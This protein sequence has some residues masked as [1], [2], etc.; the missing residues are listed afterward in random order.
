MAAHLRS[1]I[2]TTDHF[3]VKV[4]ANAESRDMV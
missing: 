2:F 1:K 3:E 4:L